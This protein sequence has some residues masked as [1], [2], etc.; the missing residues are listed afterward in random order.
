MCLMQHDPVAELKRR[1][2]DHITR[3]IAG[4][5]TWD[6]AVR[7]GIHRSELSRIRN[8]RLERF[9]LD[10]LVR[11]AAR[12]GLRVEIRVVARAGRSAEQGAEPGAGAE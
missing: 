6:R 5:N 10:R 9:S 7:A 12:L 8:G 11:C 4:W 3:A 2:A 1:V